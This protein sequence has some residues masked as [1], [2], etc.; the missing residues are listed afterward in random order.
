MG[1]GWGWGFWSLLRRLAGGAPGPQPDP[2]ARRRGFDHG[3]DH[4]F[5]R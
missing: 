1:W 4:G 5:G 3:F 2:V